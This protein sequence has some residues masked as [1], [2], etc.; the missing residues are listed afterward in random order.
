MASY[1]Q[2]FALRQDSTL[3]ARLTVAVEK[4]AVDILVAHIQSP[5]PAATIDWAR[6]ALLEKD[7]AQPYA[8]RMLRIAMHQAAGFA[9]LA[10]SA[11]DAQLQAIVDAYVPH[12]V[13]LGL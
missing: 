4:S 1:E 6:R 13:S 10:G 11:T 2:I 7:G 9:D 8:Y 3:I 12:F 5:Q